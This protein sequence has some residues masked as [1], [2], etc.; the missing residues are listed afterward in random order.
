MSIGASVGLLHAC[1]V[2]DGLELPLVPSA[3]TDAVALESSAPRDGELARDG[4]ALATESGA[5]F[6][7]GA[8]ADAALED[9]LS[10]CPITPCS[11]A[12][13]CCYVMK[14][15]TAGAYRCL[16]SCP[17]NAAPVNCAG[18]Q[19]C[20]NAAPV[21][22]G[23]MT[24]GPGVAPNCP[25]VSMSSKCTGGC[26]TNIALGCNATDTLHLCH[27][28]ADCAS[29]PSNPNCCSYPGSGLSS[30][31]CV[32]DLFKSVLSLPCAP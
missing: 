27:V 17:G 32:S 28:R 23:T 20:N 22:C 13:V 30:F 2:V 12:D 3:A 16:A 21:C 19:Q 7:S 26:S 6:D 4:N 1:S 24:V 14:S 18:P 11:G 10:L 5:G 9:A 29:D 15:P 8:G 25:A 31:L